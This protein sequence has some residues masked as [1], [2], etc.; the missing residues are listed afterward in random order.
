MTQDASMVTDGN[1]AVSTI[2]YCYHGD[3]QQLF[4][5]F[6]RTIPANNLYNLD[7]SV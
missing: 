3:C 5:V 6:I 1:M 7:I 4:L 2:F